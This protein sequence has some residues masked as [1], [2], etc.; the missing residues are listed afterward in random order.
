FGVVPDMVFV[1]EHGKKGEGLEGLWDAV[2]GGGGGNFD[3][4]ERKKRASR[5]EEE[6]QE[7]EKEEVGGEEGGEAVSPPLS[8]GDAWLMGKDAEDIVEKL[9]QEKEGDN[10]EV[11]SPNPD[12]NNN[13]NNNSNNNSATPSR[14]TEA[15]NRAK[16]WLTNVMSSANKAGK[17]AV[18][19][20][21]EP[22]WPSP[23]TSRDEDEPPPP[24]KPQVQVRAASAETRQ[25]RYKTTRRRFFNHNRAKL[26]NMDP[27]LTPI[28]P[29]RP[30]FTDSVTGIVAAGENQG[31][32]VAGSRD[33]SVAVVSRQELTAVR[34]VKGA[35]PVSMVVGKLKFGMI[36][37]CGYDD[38]ITNYK[39]GET[40]EIDRLGVHNAHDDACIDMDVVNVTGTGQQIVISGGD[41]CVVKVWAVGEDG[42]KGGEPLVDFYDAE[43]PVL[44]VAGKMVGSKDECCV[45]AGCEDGTVR[46]WVY[47]LL[48]GDQ[49]P[50]EVVGGGW[51]RMGSISCAGFV[52]DGP[53]DDMRFLVGGSGGTIRVMDYDSLGKI[54]CVCE[55]NIRTSIRDFVTDGEFIV[56]AGGNGGIYLL[57]VKER[58]GGEGGFGIET[59]KEWGGI[60][61][62]GISKIELLRQGVGGGDGAVVLVVGGDDGTMGML[63]IE[64]E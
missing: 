31:M 14:V 32:L 44:A 40:G 19:A 57:R 55:A 9:S 54:V 33:G 36:L 23:A 22:E 43:T 26:K 62:E 60:V 42:V 46:S 37:S 48:T 39:V 1:L 59:V 35:M 64:S 15:T 63:K 7:K 30:V 6:E 34:S 47:D 5:D 4:P 28:L 41:D 56:V 27:V 18:G 52:H 12:N 51:G 29:Q 17:E 2:V 8:P 16:S 25:G 24:P 10:T 13:N 11:L 3:T 49:K 21:T 45:V 38:A 58:E 61:E 50:L 53:G 20:M